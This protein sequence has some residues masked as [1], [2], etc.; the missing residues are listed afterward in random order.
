MVHELETTFFLSIAQWWLQTSA[1]AFFDTEEQG[2]VREK[3]D[4][5]CKEH[6]CVNITF[7]FSFFPL[8]N[9]GMERA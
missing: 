2:N 7:S 9:Q 1:V 8:S 4:S 3:P 5:V 6:F